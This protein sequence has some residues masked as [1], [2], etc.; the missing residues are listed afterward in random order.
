[1]VGSIK[2][3]LKG[4]EERHAIRSLC[5]VLYLFIV[6][7]MLGIGIDLHG[8]DKREAVL[9]AGEAV[10]EKPKI[11]L[12][13]DDGPNPAYT[14][15]LL[16][17]LKKRGVKATFFVLGRNVKK[18]PKLV[19]RI[20]EEGHLIGNHTYDHIELNKV[21]EEK[22]RK[23]I[24]KANKAVRKV[25]GKNPEYM[26]PPYGECSRK[27]EDSLDMILVRWTID[28]LDWKTENTDE[29]VN[30][31][32]TEAEENAIILLHD[33]YDTSVDA[34]LKIIDTLEK[35]GYEFVTVDELL[36]N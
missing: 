13:F 4:R 33:C 2:T 21:P 14:G 27:L 10:S 34:A 32:V 12:T 20:S 35:E 36:L 19:K 17:G 28:P 25:T 7:N 26:R 11:A 15:N 30:K 24:K 31:V 29:I 6:L 22:A 1:M 16:D 5:A 23:E 18:Y 9:A 3:D 8:E